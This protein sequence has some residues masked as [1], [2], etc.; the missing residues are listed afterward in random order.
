[1]KHKGHFIYEY[2]RPAVTVDAVVFRKRDTDW[3]VLLVKRVNSP[4]EGYWA[5]PGGFVDE[6]ETLEQA[7]EREL[8]EETGLKGVKLSQL[9]A[10]SN[11]RRDPRGRTI[12][13]AFVGVLGKTDMAV[14][15]SDDAGDVN[16]F[17]L[18]ELP[19]LAFDHAEIIDCAEEWLQKEVLSE[20]K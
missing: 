2:P 19:D 3:E 8:F 5:L 10:F 20:R 17:V 18:D 9:K 15:P 1:M 12:S 7:V 6:E 4:F 16:W 11:P 13:I 14:R